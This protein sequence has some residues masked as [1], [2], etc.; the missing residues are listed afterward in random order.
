MLGSYL[1]YKK[2]PYLNLPFLQSPICSSPLFCSSIQMEKKHFFL[3]EL[4]PLNFNLT[5]TRKNW[6]NHIPRFFICVAPANLIMSVV[7]LLNLIRTESC[8]CQDFLP[9]NESEIPAVADD[10]EQEPKIPVIN[11]EKTSLIWTLIAIVIL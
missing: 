10:Q 3:L 5:L 4:L 6:R 1:R 2:G 11:L 9:I 8:L 7:S